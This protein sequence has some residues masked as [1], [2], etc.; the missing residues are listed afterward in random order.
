[1]NT[2]TGG[3]AAVTGSPFAAGTTPTYLR[4]TGGH[5]Y[6]LNTGSADISG[7]TIGGL[8]AL[9]SLGSAT[10][11]TGAT[12]VSLWQWGAARVF[13]LDTGGAQIL[14]LTRN[15]TT[16]TLTLGSA[17]ATGGTVAADLLVGP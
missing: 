11:L 8:G 10:A 7:W 13:V 2:L 6:A 15:P 1:M 3:L 4:G 14:P 17:A 16:G 9:T 12:S 5:L